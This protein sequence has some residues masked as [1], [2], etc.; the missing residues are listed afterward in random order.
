M[1]RR[2]I[3]FCS[4]LFFCSVFIARADIYR[5]ISG[6]GLFVN[7]VPTGA[8]VFID[9]VE[10]G[11]TPLILPSVKEGVY[12][13]RITKEGYED[14]RIRVV[15][16]KDSRV[17]VTLDMEP[18]EGRVL[19]EIQREPSAPSSLPFNPRITVDGAQFFERSLSLP[20]GYRTITVEAFGWETVSKSVYIGRY[21]V[22][23]V[24]FVLVPAEFSL[25]DPVLRKK[26]F[27][28]LNAGTLGKADIGFTVNAPGRGLLEI[29]DENG[30]IIFTRNLK[31]FTSWQQRELWDGRRN[32][33]STVND[34]NYTIRIT[35][36]GEGAEERQTAEMK[37]Q[38]DSSVEVRPFTIASSSAGLLLAS[39]P[40]ILPAYSFQIEGSFLAGKPLFGGAW[41]SL[42]F[43]LAF[44]V[45]LTDDLEIGAAFN[46]EPRFKDYTEWGAG[47]SLKWR[48]LKPAT[49]R[50]MFT[51]AFGA[52][53]EISYGW[54]AK[55]PYTAFGMGTG[56]ALR[57]PLSYRLSG[58]AASVSDPS[59]DL[60]VSPLVLWAGESG[61][62]DNSIPRVGVEGGALFSYRSIAAGLSLRW[63]YQPG[64]ENPNPVFPGNPLVTALEL[65]IM[66]S[67]F[68]FSVLGGY[69]YC[70][71]SSG[72][73]FG[74]SLGVLF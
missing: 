50:N 54:A 58:K 26:R 49:D 12:R 8:K 40:E 64:T 10:R 72:A 16:R 29:L 7:T 71:G 23:Q 22:Q 4:F 39:S 28:P 33:G 32:D 37:V 61:Y 67:N 53:V 15:I 35:V 66:P 9:G 19:L 6:S 45:S 36:W 18:A 48:F 57:L 38:V 43:A 34:G 47:A 24:D 13:L 31:L 73:F 74:A 20:V 51:D 42:P 17:E 14:R 65:K 46:A 41:K 62:P 3:F 60:L 27:N 25:K 44:R 21:T 5:E 1:I 30:T 55:G 11:T 70:K 68:I 2:R 52:A 69:W 56:A 63:D 59:F